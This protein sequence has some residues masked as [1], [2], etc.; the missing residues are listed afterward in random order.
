MFK[1]IT[2]IKDL[3]KSPSCHEKNVKLYDTEKQEVADSALWKRQGKVQ[4]FKMAPPAIFQLNPHATDVCSILWLPVPFSTLLYIPR[5][6]KN[7]P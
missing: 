4:K 6:G 1:C 2:L 3:K 5:E 7:M